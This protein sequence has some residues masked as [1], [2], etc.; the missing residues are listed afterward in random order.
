MCAQAAE[1]APPA[2]ETSWKTQSAL[3]K[4][5]PELGDGG[6]DP[7]PGNFCFKT[8]PASFKAGMYLTFSKTPA[9]RNLFFIDTKRLRR[10][11]PDN[12]G[13]AH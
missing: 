10:G 9:I 4:Q 11:L 5:I 2:T 1:P 12:D 3:F 8:L 7:L 13:D 6:R